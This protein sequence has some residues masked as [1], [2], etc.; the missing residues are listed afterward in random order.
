[1]ILVL[2]II[3]P[4]AVPLWGSTNGFKAP[5]GWSP[6]RFRPLLYRFLVPSVDLTPFPGTTLGLEIPTVLGGEG[7]REEVDCEAVMMVE[8]SR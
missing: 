5:T 2:L 7:G 1:M 4:A 3:G 6:R 8:N